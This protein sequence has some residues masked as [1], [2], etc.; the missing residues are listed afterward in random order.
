MRSRLYCWRRSLMDSLRHGRLS[1]RLASRALV[2]LARVFSSPK[3]RLELLC[4]AARVYSQPE[5]LRRLRPA[6]EKEASQVAETLTQQSEAVGPVNLPKAL[7]VKPPV[8]EQE[9][10]LIYV[11][12]EDHWLRLLRSGQANA[13]ANR[14]D[15]LLGPSTS[16][17]PS[18]EMVL[19]TRLWPGPLYSLLSNFK[20]S[21]LMTVLSQRLIP[22]PLLASSWVDPEPFVPHL[23]PTKDY[24]IAMLAHFHPVK[25]HWLLFQAMQK[26][27]KRFRVL[28]MGVPLGGRTEAH[29]RAEARLFGVENRFDLILRPS[30]EQVMEGLARSR[31]S[32]IFSRREGACIAVAESLFADTPVGLFREAHVGSRAFINGRTGLLLDRPAL[33]EQLQALVE[34]AG[35]YRPRDWALQHIS[36][37]VSRKTLNTIRQ[38]AAR[39]EERPWT[40]DL[41][42]FAKGLVPY[43]LSPEVESE[44]MP[45]YEDFEARY[46]IRL[47]PVARAA[48]PAERRPVAA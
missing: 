45:H 27:P 35:E 28:L 1:A 32:L 33:V 25:R 3:T 30:R 41:V 37:H 23:R 7:I 13:I 9:K 40:R 14:Y 31:V 11:T 17:P 29:L 24:D 4:K 38:H 34:T 42:P 20:D 15:L 18:P 22:V 44:M 8:S 46:G 36:C 6:L 21:A 19:M 12:F 47:G 2:W 39:R 10:G 26:L 43:Y 5:R 16:P 48:A